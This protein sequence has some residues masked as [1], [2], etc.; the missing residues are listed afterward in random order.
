MPRALASDDVPRLRRALLTWF[1]RKARTLPWRLA[2]T[3]YQVLVSEVMLQQTQ[4]ATVIPYFRRFLN[5]F[6]NV[7][8]LAAAPVDRV[9]ELWSGMGY[10]RRARNLHRCAQIVVKEF[11]GR[12]PA[13]YERAR[14][15]PGVGDYTARAVLSIAYNLPYSVMDGNVARVIARLAALTGGPGDPVFRRAVAHELDS[16][17]SRR[18]PG[19]FNQ[20]MMELGQTVCLPR[21]PRCGA[22]PLRNWCH[23]RRVGRPESFPAPKRR[24]A[25][26]AHHLAVAIITRQNRLALVRGLDGGLLPDM[27]NFP[28]AFG[29]S[30]DD[31][32]H[33]LRRK[34][35]SLEN[36]SAE[37][38]QSLG[39]LRHN[40]TF[41]AIHVHLVS[42][43]FP[44][45]HDLF[46]WLS[47]SQMRR[48]AISK[49]ARKILDCIPHGAL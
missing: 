49:L 46:H 27:W 19:N 17:I 12:L 30:R 41:R 15:L 9:L 11:G 16:L 13:D 33:N 8:A 35:E 28:A 10:Y 48:A 32:M 38:G 47:I 18:Q 40:I 1:Q 4:V 36:G 37:L 43:E 20:A 42:A 14:S 5:A 29:R 44:K 45:G 39:K 21:A 24:R 25:S 6:P 3:P 31:A 34:L 7:R 22:C 2:P 23:A 26:E